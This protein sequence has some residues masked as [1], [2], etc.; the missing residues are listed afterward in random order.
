MLL[1]V[2]H[3]SYLLL[4]ARDAV[5]PVYSLQGLSPFSSPPPA[6]AA[7]RADVA[8]TAATT[9]QFLLFVLLLL[10]EDF[11]ERCSHLLDELVLRA[12]LLQLMVL[13][14]LLSMDQLSLYL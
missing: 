1:P 5:S 10:L 4:H 14:L 13:H 2:S 6:A 11:E 9:S 12:D 7:D 3:I 8:W